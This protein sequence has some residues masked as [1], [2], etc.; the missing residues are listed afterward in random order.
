MSLNSRSIAKILR[1][2]FTGETPIIKNAFEHQAFISSLQTEIEKIKGI[3]KR[4]FYDKEPE[5]KYDFSIKD[6]S[7]FYDY[8]YF[9][10]KFNQSN[11]L[12]MSHNGSRATVYQIEQIFSFIDRIK[13]EYDNKN[14]RQL[15]KEKIN[16]LK[17]LAIIGK[18]KKIAKE[19]KFDFYTREYATKLK[20]IVEIELGKI[21]EIDIPYSEFQDTLK[22]LRSLIQTIKELQK[23]GLTFRFKSSSKYKHASWITHQSL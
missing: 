1:E 7:C 6:E 18:I 17:Q 13:Q 3:E 19:D 16:K 5:Q 10:I 15:K 2:H 14:A 11:E 20:L 12:I 8:D 23:L 4:S 21:M 22:E 9:T